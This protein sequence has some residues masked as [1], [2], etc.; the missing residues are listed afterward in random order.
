[1]NDYTKEALG[2]LRFTPQFAVDLIYD[3][4]ECLHEVL[5]KNNIRYTIFGGT[6]L[7]T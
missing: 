6:A 5:T 4:L 3:T 2:R 1:M 7:G